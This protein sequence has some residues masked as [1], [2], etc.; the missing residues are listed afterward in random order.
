MTKLLL[1]LLRMAGLD[2]LRRIASGVGLVVFGAWVLGIAAI[3]GA[4]AAYQ[5]L[6]LRLEPWA[7]ASVIGGVLALIG[8]V[9]CWIGSA[10]MRG[11]SRR[12][13]VRIA[14]PEQIA[15]LLGLPKGRNV[16]ALQMVTIAAIVGFALGRGR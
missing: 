11:Q 10:R 4:I 8:A 3:F 12:R 14:V 13:E 16:S 15:P 6:L 2:R 1:A 5:S 9:V 7:A